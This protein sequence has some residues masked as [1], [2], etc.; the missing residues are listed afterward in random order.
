M[1]G[2]KLKR[3]SAQSLISFP[4]LQDSKSSHMHGVCLLVKFVIG[5]F[6]GVSETVF[7]RVGAVV[8]M[9]LAM[10]CTDLYLRWL[11]LFIAVVSPSSSSTPSPLAV[12]LLPSSSTIYVF[13]H[14]ISHNVRS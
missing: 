4:W 11:E 9:G 1:S 6:I 13:G 7:L 12:L 5:E 10:F 14:N 3:V 2:L 8:E